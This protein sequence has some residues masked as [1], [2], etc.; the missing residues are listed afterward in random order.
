[1]ALLVYSDKCK[2]SFEIISFIKMNPAL[3]EIIRYHNI[4]TQGIPS[5]KIT[6]VPTL[7]TNDGEMFVG[8]DVKKWL[9]NMVPIE[10]ESWCDSPGL[11]FNLDGTAQE[12]MFNIDNYGDT[13]EPELTPELREK[14]SRPV[15]D[16]S[17]A[18]SRT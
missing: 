6:R 5:S 1:M 15:S 18:L 3:N 2:W 4:N 7:V 9:Q 10:L 17:I 8:A 13:L 16:S 14:I 12:D 11:C